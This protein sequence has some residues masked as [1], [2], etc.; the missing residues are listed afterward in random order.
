MEHA[1][2]RPRRGGR[3]DPASGTIR[4]RGGPRADAGR[5]APSRSRVPSMRKPAALLVLA[6]ALALAAPDALACTNIL[7]TKGAS[8]DGSTMITYA[9]DSHELYGE[10]Y[11]TPGRRPPLRRDAR[12]RRVGH[13][14]DARPHPAG[15]GDLPGRREHERAPGRDRR[16]DLG[17]PQG[18]RRCRPASSTTARSCG[19]RLERSKTAR[20]AIEVMTKLDGRVRLRL[21][22]GVALHRRPERGLGPG[23]HRQ[24]GEAE[25][26][27]LGRREGPRRDDRRP[28]E[29]AARPRVPAQRPEERRLLEGRRLLRPREGVVHGEGRGVL[30]RRRLRAAPR[31]DPPRAATRASGASSAARRRR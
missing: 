22:G 24:G 26:G 5:A 31:R 30:L 15:A 9:A 1:P 8:A 28:R 17:R 14:Q 18:A 27:R 12:D 25:G 29:P 19:S 10:L 21:G 11:F 4:G 3:G 7:V 13:R 2:P 16:D 6:T 23:D 20:E